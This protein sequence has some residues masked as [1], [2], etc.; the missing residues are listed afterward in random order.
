MSGPHDLPRSSR[1]MAPDREMHD[2]EQLLERY[3]ESTQ[4]RASAELVRRFQVRL[5]QEPAS[6]PPRRFVA[7]LGAFAP[8][9][10]A[11]AFRQS[12]GAIVGQ[13]H[14]SALVRLQAIGLLLAA[15]LVLGT[16]VGGV[17]AVI[18]SVVQPPDR[19]AP[20]TPLPSRAPRSPEVSAS[21]A[22][23]PSP[24][25]LVTP[26]PTQT[27][28]ARSSV[29]R[30]HA[31]HFRKTPPRKVRRRPR[32]QATAT[33]RPAKAP[34]PASTP[35]P[36]PEPTL[37]ATPTL[38]P[39]PIPTPDPT[40]EPTRAPGP[41]PASEPPDPTREPEPPNIPRATRVPLDS[42]QPP[43]GPPPR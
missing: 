10:A 1:G 35:G 25:V 42:P 20:Q 40:P 36:T 31:S 14:V 13:G 6:T 17:G 29:T 43:D 3:V 22:P 23:S 24:T 12:L 41:T 38:A 39:T 15:L 4:I 26:R 11:R 37:G 34:R 2:V 7:A 8:R 33:P 16:V 9:A 30:G 28:P 32:P 19:S 21:P 5:A 27:P 18:V